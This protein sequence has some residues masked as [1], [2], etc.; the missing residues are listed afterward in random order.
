MSHIEQAKSV[1]DALPEHASTEEIL[2]QIKTKADLDQSVEF[3]KILSESPQEPQKSSLFDSIA[4]FI[5]PIII[6]A[7]FV[8]GIPFGYKLVLGGKKDR[9]YQGTIIELQIKGLTKDQS[10][11]LLNSKAEIVSDYLVIENDKQVTLISEEN[12]SHLVLR[13]E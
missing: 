3:G 9:I 13:K 1:I 5:I 2:Y 6:I 4:G 11:K 7:L 8:L 12:I 10:D